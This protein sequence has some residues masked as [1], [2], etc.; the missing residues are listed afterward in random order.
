IKVVGSVLDISDMKY[1]AEKIQESLEEKESLI[2][3]LYHRTKNNMQ[4]ICSMLSFRTREIKDESI[5][6]VFNDMKNRIYSMALVHQKLYS[7]KSLARINLREY[8]VELTG[9]V[10]RSYERAHG[11]ISTRFSMEDVFVNIDTAI[12][13]GVALHEL[14]ANTCKYAFAAGEEGEVFMSLHEHPGG[15]IEFVMAD[16]GTG[17]ELV[18]GIPVNSRMGLKTA[19]A[20]ICDQLHGEVR[21]ESEKGLKYMIRFRDLEK[22]HRY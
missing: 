11:H 1:A 5:R 21:A 6:A 17:V 4:V 13:F 16:N 20:L 8:V 10:I 12:P 3:E 7:S 22:K 15:V 14:V 19:Y 9:T 2:R 18:D